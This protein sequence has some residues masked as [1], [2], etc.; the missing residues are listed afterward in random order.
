MIGH[1]IRL[2]KCNVVVVVI[3]MC[4]NHQNQNF[5]DNDNNLSI[6]NCFIYIFCFFFDFFSAF[7]VSAPVIKSNGLNEER[8]KKKWKKLRLFD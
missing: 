5:D 8:S 6:R 7:N 4:Y 2:N 1:M 3:S